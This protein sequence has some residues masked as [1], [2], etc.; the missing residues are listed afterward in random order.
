MSIP[1]PPTLERKI[2]LRLLRWRIRARVQLT[3]LT[4]TLSNPLSRPFIDVLSALALWIVQQLLPT[5]L[6]WLKSVFGLILIVIVFQLSFR[7]PWSLSLKRGWRFII[8][9]FLTALALLLTKMSVNESQPPEYLP[10]TQK[11][12]AELRQLFQNQRSTPGHQTRLDAS[13]P[14]LSVQ[15]LL[16]PLAP[17]S[18]RNFLF[19]IGETSKDRFSAYIQ[20][21][22]IIVALIDSFGEEYNLKIPIT[23]GIDFKNG[24]ISFLTCEY[25]VGSDY[26]IL[27]ARVNGIEVG[28]LELPK[29]VDVA[30]ITPRPS[31]FAVGCD[32]NRSNGGV[33]ESLLLQTFPRTLTHGEVERTLS[34]ALQRSTNPVRLRF[35]GSDCMYMSST[36]ARTMTLSSESMWIGNRPELSN[37]PRLQPSLVID[38]LG[39]RDGTQFHLRI[40]NGKFPIRGLQ[41]AF[42][43]G[44][45]MMFDTLPTMGKRDLAP[46]ERLMMPGQLFTDLAS[47]RR[48]LAVFAFGST[49][50][51]VA[52]EY[53][54]RYRFQLPNGNISAGREFDPVDKLE[55]DGNT[56]KVERGKVDKD[57]INRVKQLI[58]G[59]NNK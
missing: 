47:S 29:K 54:I 48:L 36:S 30:I 37:R 20:D 13:V 39:G 58:Q 5:G 14:G 10:V 52:K 17:H 57:F 6:R 8:F 34:R 59:R 42:S 18:G 22:T 25:G 31:N 44:K 24:N 21:N 33:F 15:L 46:G 32:L 19:D 43:T 26:T 50:D 55:E 40:T 1:G 53:T 56:L 9:L 2:F 4:K 11:D 12:F 51:G 23:T 16:R 38:S 35:S 28:A 27:R 45:D 49:V 41:V 3:D 7:T